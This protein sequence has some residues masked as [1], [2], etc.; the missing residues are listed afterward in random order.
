M[1][2]ARVTVSLWLIA[3]VPLSVRLPV[4]SVPEVPPLP[5]W[6]VPAEMVVGPL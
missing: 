4:P 3:R 6:S 2:L 5:T 1:L